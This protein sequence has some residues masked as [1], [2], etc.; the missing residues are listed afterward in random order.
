[1]KLR[2]FSCVNEGW[3]RKG[4]ILTFKDV[5]R[6]AILGGLDPLKVRRHSGSQGLGF[7]YGKTCIAQARILSGELRTDVA[8]ASAEHP[9]LVLENGAALGPEELDGYDIVQAKG[10]EMIWARGGPQGEDREIEDRR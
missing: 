5:Q 4:L 2:C 7:Y 6:L 3:A 10:S 9:V 8:G 1:M